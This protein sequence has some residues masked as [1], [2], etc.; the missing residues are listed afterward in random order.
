MSRD[1]LP[2]TAWTS[3]DIDQIQI[4]KSCSPR[5]VSDYNMNDFLSTWS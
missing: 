2:A 4:R 5:K 3:K 1:V